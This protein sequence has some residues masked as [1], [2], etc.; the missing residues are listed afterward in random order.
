MIKKDIFSSL[1]NT[2]MFVLS[3]RNEK[4]M[5][6][7]LKKEFGEAASLAHVLTSEPLVI[8]KPENFPKLSPAQIKL[9]AK[10]DICAQYNTHRLFPMEAGEKLKKQTTSYLLEEFNDIPAMTP[11]VLRETDM[12]TIVFLFADARVQGKKILNVP[13][14]SQI[15][16]TSAPLP[17]P[18]AIPTIVTDVGLSI[19]KSLLGKGADAA[20]AKLFPPQLPSYFNQV[21]AEIRKIVHEEL[22]QKTLD[23]TSFKL[24]G[25]VNWLTHEYLDRKDSFKKRHPD[26]LTK[27]EKTD[28][29]GML[30]RYDQL[31]WVEVVSILSGNRYRKAGLPFF[32]DAANL[33]LLCLTELANVDPAFDSPEE[34]GYGS[35]RRNMAELYCSHVKRTRDDIHGDRRKLLEICVICGIVSRGTVIPPPDKYYFVDRH[36][37]Y[38]SGNYTDGSILD[39]HPQDGRRLC[40]LAMKKYDDEVFEPTI[41]NDLRVYDDIV[42]AWELLFK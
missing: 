21:Y 3:C 32:V 28:L 11:V 27:E 29:H 4:D 16:F 38:Q 40:G 42:K 20:L 6:T 35:T 26:G 31:F 19:A 41:T 23:D 9:I 33:H 17:E 25:I 7:R 1:G 18:L 39:K 5:D 37:N 24:Q 15:L 12:A 34:S 14:L 13:N 2:R 22:D 36:T 30:S 8:E 10:R